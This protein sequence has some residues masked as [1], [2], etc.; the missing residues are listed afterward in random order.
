MAVLIVIVET[1]EVSAGLE[2]NQAVDEYPNNSSGVRSCSRRVR[3][4]GW[5]PQGPHC[6]APAPTCLTGTPAPRCSYCFP[7]WG[8][9]FSLWL[10]N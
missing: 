10:S 9:T 8:M 5:L 1:G 2:V 3:A 4:A 6:Q 7:I